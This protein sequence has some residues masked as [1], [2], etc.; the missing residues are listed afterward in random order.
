MVLI[1]ASLYLPEHVAMIARRAYYYALGDTENI[2]VA[3]R[4]VNTAFTKSD[5]LS[6]TDGVKS[7][8]KDVVETITR[9]AQ[10]AAESV[11]SAVGAKGEL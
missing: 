9:T 7:A 5:A 8:A 1:A 6:S 2:T 11:T 10:R 4:G 3:A